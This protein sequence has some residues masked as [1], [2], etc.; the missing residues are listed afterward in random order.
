M[1]KTIIWNDFVL[2][3]EYYQGEYRQPPP[4]NYRHSQADLTEWEDGNQG[5]GGEY[6]QST[7]RQRG[8]RPDMNAYRNG[9]NSKEELEDQDDRR[10]R[11]EFKRA[12]GR[13][14]DSAT[15]ISNTVL[16]HLHQIHRRPVNRVSIVLNCFKHVSC[17]DSHQMILKNL[18]PLISFLL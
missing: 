14:N 5:R 17:R 15:V 16:N 3:Q 13:F 10:R 4:A 1:K 12:E 2:L 7:P 18:N 6:A 8:D 9:N 11:S